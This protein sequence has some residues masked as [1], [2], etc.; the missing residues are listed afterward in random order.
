MRGSRFVKEHAIAVRLRRRGFSIVEIE[1]KMDINRSTLSGWFKN[2]QLGEREKLRLLGHW[3]K[4]LSDARGRAVKW[5]NAQK[6]E[7]LLVAEKDAE[8]VVSRLNIADQ[9]V[10]ELALA[11]LYWGEGFKNDGKP[12]MGNTDP[13]MLQFYIYVLREVFFVTIDAL[14]AQL[15]LRADQ[16][17]KDEVA[18]WSKELSLPASNFKWTQFNSRTFGK[19]TYPSYHGVC[20]IYCHKVAIQRKLASISRLFVGRLLK[21]D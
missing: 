11:M 8:K 5:H 7:R 4:G 2:I 12:G 21:R 16:N 19:K 9:N 17:E 14:T 3:R 10:L 15:H 18:Y 1:K 13:K 6:K 20:T